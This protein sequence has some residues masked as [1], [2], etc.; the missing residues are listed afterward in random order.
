MKTF[1]Y[2]YETTA[3]GQVDIE[4]VGNCA[5]AAYN[6][7]QYK[8]SFILVKT[9]EGETRVVISGP[10]WVELE[11]PCDEYSFTFQS[12]QY[13]QFKIER[14]IEKFLNGRFFVDQVV[15]MKIDDALDEIP[16]VR[17]YIK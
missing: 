17:E 8:K 3:T 14:L 1:E 15:V 13:N 12:F 10:H 7:V 2:L 16:D 5:L 11:K 9:V 4:D 6:S